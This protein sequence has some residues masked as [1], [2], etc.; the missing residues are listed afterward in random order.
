MTGRKTLIGTG[1]E[2]ERPN[3]DQEKLPDRIGGGTQTPKPAPEHQGTPGQPPPAPDSEDS[4]PR[5][6]ESK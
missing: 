3:P 2:G 6:P 5:G 1:A 4:R